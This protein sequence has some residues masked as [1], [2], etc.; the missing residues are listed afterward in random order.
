[1][2]VNLRLLV[3]GTTKYSD[4]SLIL[5][6]YT[7]ELGRITLMLKGVRNAKRGS[8]RTAL[9]QP[10]NHLEAVV[11]Y[12]PNR[13]MHYL[14]E[15]KVYSVYKT[16]HQDISKSSVILFLSDILN[17]VLREEQQ[18]N[19]PLFHFLVHALDWFDC[20]DKS[21]NFHLKFLMEFTKFLGLYPNFSGTKTDFFDLASGSYVSQEPDE[22][23]LTDPLL[24]HWESLDACSFE[25]LEKLQ[26]NQQIRQQLLSQIIVYYRLHIQQFKEPKSLAVLHGLFN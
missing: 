16:L 19:E 24:K 11:D 3:L 20:T 15:A 4:S 12:K 14:K 23:G 21:A 2:T 5:H 25:S 10:L 13:G 8:I 6:G 7:P 26:L 18:E 9:F 22:N 1:M 17:Q